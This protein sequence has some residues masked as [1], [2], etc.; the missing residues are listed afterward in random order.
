MFQ[1]LVDISYDQSGNCA[2]FSSNSKD[3]SLRFT[4][5]SSNNKERKEKVMN[6]FN[7]QANLI[8]Q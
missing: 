8:T 4:R 5:D 6:V 3:V 1:P 7:L 2:D